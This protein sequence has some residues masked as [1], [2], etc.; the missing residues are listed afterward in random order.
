MNNVNASIGIENLKGINQRINQAR[1]NA[2][3]YRDNLPQHLKYLA[4]LKGFKKYLPKF[5]AYFGK[6]NMLLGKLSL[7]K[8]EKY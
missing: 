8:M 4:I 1:E 5:F 3:Y 2:K 6:F 7:L